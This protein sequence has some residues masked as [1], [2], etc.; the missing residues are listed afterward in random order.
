MNFN[1]H[2]CEGRRNSRTPHRPTSDLFISNRATRSLPTKTVQ[3]GSE[4]RYRQGCFGSTQI[5]KSSVY[6]PASIIET[7]TF[8]CDD[9]TLGHCAAA[10]LSS[11]ALER[12]RLQHHAELRD[13]VGRGDIQA[14]KANLLASGDDAELV[15]NLAPG[16]ANTLLYVAAEAGLTEVVL[17]LLAGGADGRAH[18]VT[19]YSPLY[20]ASYHGHAD[21]ARTLLSHLPRAAQVGMTKSGKK[22]TGR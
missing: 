20:A 11:D 15:V 17:A 22:I 21:I 13:A 5:E 19:R 1:F 10:T 12:Q 14:V 6:L 16:G 18:P 3:C 2:V 9:D 4:A 7:D 8:W